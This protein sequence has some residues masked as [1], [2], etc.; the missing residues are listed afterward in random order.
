[1]KTFKRNFII[2]ALL[3]CSVAAMSAQQHITNFGIVDMNKIYEHYFRKH[4]ANA[5]YGQGNNK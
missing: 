3:I 4:G 1:M 5:Y 2:M